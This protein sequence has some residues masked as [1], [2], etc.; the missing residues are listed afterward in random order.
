MDTFTGHGPIRYFEHSENKM[1]KD[2][3]VQPGMAAQW[4]TVND[5]WLAEVKKKCEGYNESRKILAEM[6]PLG[7]QELRFAKNEDLSIL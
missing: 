7:D 6:K 4:I 3:R 5:E 1:N 2:S